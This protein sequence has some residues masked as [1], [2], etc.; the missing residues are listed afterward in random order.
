MHAGAEVQ[1]LLTH[2][3]PGGHGVPQ[4]PQCAASF[5]RCVSH[6][7]DALTLQSSQPALHVPVVHA[8]CA[9]VV[10]VELANTQDWLQ[11]PQFNA[12]LD[13]S[14]Q[15]PLQFIVPALHSQ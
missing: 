9:Q 11:A 15:V 12:S 2:A 13:T 8:P 6:P 3:L 4:A 14:V 1:A 5:A 7:S 10:P